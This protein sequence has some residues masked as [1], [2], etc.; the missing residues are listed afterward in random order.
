[1]ICVENPKCVGNAEDEQ[2]EYTSVG[3]TIAARDALAKY[4]RTKHKPVLKD[5]MT[6]LVMWFLSL[7]PAVRTAALDSVDEGMEIAYAAALEAM[8][9]ELRAKWEL[10]HKARNVGKPKGAKTPESDPS[11][12]DPEPERDARKRP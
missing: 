2:V 3:I 1:M 4:L 7:P 6:T 10:S 11:A 8:A 5:V 9:A 12:R